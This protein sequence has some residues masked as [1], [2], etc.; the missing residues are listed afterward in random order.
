[1]A[2]FE[3]ETRVRAPLDQVWEF[4]SSIDGLVALTPHWMHLRVER[5]VGPDGEENPDVLDV[6]SRVRLSVRPFDVG[7]RQRWTSVI[8]DREEQDGMAFFRDEMTEGPFPVWRHTHQFFGDGDETLVRDRVEYRTPFGGLAD[9][10]APPF[11][12]YFF[13]GRHR[14]TRELLETGRS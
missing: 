10:L 14:R 1:M 2:T 3:R 9:P 11:F 5:V 7:P 6:G 4:H 12:A 8:T 13:D